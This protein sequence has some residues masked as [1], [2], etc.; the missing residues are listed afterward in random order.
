MTLNEHKKHAKLARPA[1]GNFGR[2]EWG[3]IG[4]PCTVIKL[5]A[6]DVIGAFS[7]TYKCAYADTSHND[8][9][10]LVPGR[11]TNGAILDYTD[12]INYQD[13]KSVV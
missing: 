10:T 11:L 9:I 7:P 4:G 3:I 6:H 1:S 5:L 8:D 12:Q 2:N 13:R